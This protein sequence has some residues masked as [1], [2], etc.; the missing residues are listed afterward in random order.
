MQPSF[1][2]L[3]TNA[4]KRL[5]SGPVQHGAKRCAPRHSEIGVLVNGAG[6]KTPDVGALPKHVR[7]AG[8]E[9]GRCLHQATK[10]PEVGVC[11][12]RQ[13]TGCDGA[14]GEAYSPHAQPLRGELHSRVVRGTCTVAALFCR[15]TLSIKEF[16]EFAAELSLKSLPHTGHQENAAPA[17]LGMRFYRCCPPARGRR[18]PAPGSSWW[19]CAAAATR[20]CQ[21]NRCAS[22][23]I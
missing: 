23:I 15:F 11:S 2:L 20:V 6:Y 18:C 21:S 12:G 19:P 17:Q 22:S 9:A 7:E 10:A 5:M 3:Y 8:R 14:A 13:G 1:S 4:Q 16:N